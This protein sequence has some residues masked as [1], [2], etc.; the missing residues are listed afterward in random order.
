[1]PHTS[2]SSESL[3]ETLNHLGTL[4]QGLAANADDLPHLDSHRQQ[5]EGL[6]TEARTV[7]SEQRIQTAA[8]QDLSRRLEVLM[9]RA[10]KLGAFLRAGVRQHYGTRSEKLVE[11]DMLPFRGKRLPVQPLPPPVPE[12]IQV[13]EREAEG[14]PVR[15]TD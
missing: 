3:G 4:S 7:Q 1:M 13:A 6:V 11:F 10:E 12:T 15:V 5:L 14:Q 2:R 8:K 9:E